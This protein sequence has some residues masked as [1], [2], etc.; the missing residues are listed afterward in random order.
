MAVRSAV[1]F[2]KYGQLFKGGGYDPLTF[3]SSCI[4]RAPPPLPPPPAPGRPHIVIIYTHNSYHLQVDRYYGNKPVLQCDWPSI[5]RCSIIFFGIN[6]GCMVS[7][8]SFA[9]YRAFN[10]QNVIL[11][12]LV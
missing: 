11:G 7:V 6:H 9:I 3:S 5:I 2:V 4:P 8:C 10:P 1:N 12:I